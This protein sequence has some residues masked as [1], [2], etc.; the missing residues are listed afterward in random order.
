MNKYIFKARVVVEE[1]LTLYETHVLQPL[2]E[3][4]NG[5]GSDVDTDQEPAPRHSA[6]Q[7][8][9]PHPGN[10]NSHAAER[11]MDGDEQSDGQGGRQ[12]D[13]SE[14]DAV[15]DPLAMLR[16]MGSVEYG[17]WSPAARCHALAWLCDEAMSSATMNDLVRKVLEAREGVDRRDREVMR[18]A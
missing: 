5:A 6:S 17:W 2:S 11:D 16:E 3:L 7:N 12:T 18:D 9:V 8:F 15:S 10:H 4:E 1:F 13:R 14:V